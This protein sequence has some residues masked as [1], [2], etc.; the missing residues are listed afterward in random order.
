M[1]D[2]SVFNLPGMRDRQWELYYDG[3][4]A[5]DDPR[6]TDLNELQERMVETYKTGQRFIAHDAIKLALSD[7]TFPLIFLDFETTNPAIPRY[8][9]CGPFQHVPF[10]FSVHRWQHADADITHQEFLFDT[11]DDPR[12]T[13]IPALLDACGNEG[14][15]VAYYGKFESARI[16][17]L[18]RFLP[19]HQDALHQLTARIVDPL[20]I[21][22]H[23]IY[24]NAFHGSFSLKNVAPAL[25]GEAQSYE[26]MLIKNGGEAQRAFDELISPDTSPDR[27]ALLRDAML[28]YCKKD[29]LVMVML[30]KWLQITISNLT[31]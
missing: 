4:V 13:L 19:A 23:H 8:D 7:W 21:I 16:E 1:P 6:L 3:M 17:E 14:S 26:N 30:V 24:D 11:A 20:P 27:K 12:P 18:A 2:L 22:R 29:T 5:L 28:A 15:I 10:Q 25:L 31:P 9:G